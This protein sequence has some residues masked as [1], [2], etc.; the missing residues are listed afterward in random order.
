MPL[1]RCYFACLFLFLLSCN[2]LCFPFCTFCGEFFLCCSACWFGSARNGFHNILW[3]TYGLLCF[4]LGFSTC[5]DTLPVRCLNLPSIPSYP[6]VAILFFLLLLRVLRVILPFLAL[7]LGP[8]FAFILLSLAAH[9]HRTFACQLLSGRFHFEAICCKFAACCMYYLAS[10]WSCLYFA[11]SVGSSWVLLCFCIFGA[12]FGSPYCLA[13]LFLHFASLFALLY[14][15]FFF[16]FCFFFFVLF[17][18]LF[19]HFNFL[20]LHF[21]LFL[22]HFI[23][24]FCCIFRLAVCF[25]CFLKVGLQ[26]LL[27]WLLFFCIVFAILLFVRFLELATRARDKTSS[28]SSIVA[29][30]SHQDL[31]SLNPPPCCSR[32]ESL[33][34][35]NERANLSLENCGLIS[36]F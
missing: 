8:C 22:L 11:V 14:F 2:I 3:L 33:V 27:H 16:F 30:R 15:S 35:G 13:W 29:A 9:R 4:L 7:R 24:F 12:F 23:C 1:C 21:M 28:R 18:L 20:E 36:L 17:L 32:I 19:L 10:C 34:L 6:F 26:F 25:I 31:R 5:A